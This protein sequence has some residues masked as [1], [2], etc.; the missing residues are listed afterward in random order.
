MG[1]RWPGK[2]A[3]SVRDMECWK[4]RLDRLLLLY[5][6]RETESLNSGVKSDYSRSKG[7]TRGV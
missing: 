5:R 1:N 7:E 6:E 3:F 4:L 2:C